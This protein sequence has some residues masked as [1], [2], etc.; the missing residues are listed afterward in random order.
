[1]SVTTVNFTQVHAAIAD[2]TC[3]LVS[4]GHS[5]SSSG[6]GLFLGAI[7]KENLDVGSPDRAPFISGVTG[8]NS[9]KVASSR[10]GAFEFSV[11]GSID[12]NSI[13]SAT[14]NVYVNSINQNFKNSDDWMFLAAFETE[15]PS[16]EYSVGG[17]DESLYPAINNDYSYEAVMWSNERCSKSNLGWKTIDVKRAVVHALEK[18]GSKSDEVKVVIR[19]H[20]PA[21]GLNVSVAGQ[22]PSISVKT[23]ESVN[24]IIKTV[25]QNGNSIL[26]DKE[27]SSGIGEFSYYEIIDKELNINDVLYLF[28]SNK[29]I[30]NITMEKGK[31]NVIVLVYNN[32]GE[33]RKYSGTTL[34]DDGATC[35]FADPRSVTFEHENIFENNTLV[36]PAS[37]KTIVGAIDDSGTVKAV[38]CDNIT[39]EKK[40]IIIDTGFE[41][42]DHNNPTFL[43]L[44]DHRIMVFWSKHTSEE[45][46]YYRVTQEPDDLTTLGEEK[47][48]SVEGYGDFTYP[49][50]FYMSDAPDSFFICWRGVNWHPTIAKYSLPDEND[51]I[52]CEKEPTQIVQT[53]GQR[54]YVKYESNGKD[55]IY[56]TFTTAHPDNNYPNWVYYSEID[57]NTFDLYNI[58]GDI[59]CEGEN[60][61]LGKDEQINTSSD[62]G[63]LTVDNPD[64]KRDWVWDIAVDK[65]GS[66]VILFTQ[67]S[68]DK[69][70]HDYYYAKW[71]KETKTWDKTYIANGGGWFHQNDSGK[72][73]CYSGGMCL[74]HSDPSLV[75]VSKPT[76]GLYGNIYEIWELKMEDMEV[77]SETQI[78]ENSQF[79]NVRPFVAKGS[80]PD[81][82]LRLTWMNGLYYYWVSSSSLPNAF[83]TSIMTHYNGP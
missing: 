30:T 76:E 12:P 29:S 47:R 43:Y 38:Q 36:L 73:K 68:N 34:I 23:D 83:P 18:D 65:D 17:M 1:M 37:S 74:D 4:Y 24:G 63:S 3:N 35:W 70:Q 64:N 50:P 82:Y 79:N 5:G 14:M 6:T 56:F 10:V 78:T 53:I 26:P 19:L 51:N 21:C 13:V 81:D 8:N 39:D 25:D 46:W 42:D 28:D 54:P 72:E 27:F 15:N 33:M 58:E 62:Y 22:V 11:D 75:Y 59:L 49:S 55:K 31:E 41:P 52:V 32:T 66:I 57:I 45:Y 80:S 67:I 20:V 7:G 69:S 60:L 9:V 44:P 71:N 40:E 2:Y 16:L 61:P 48:V 77:V